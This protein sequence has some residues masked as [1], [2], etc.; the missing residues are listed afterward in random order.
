MKITLLNRKSL[1]KVNNKVEYDKFTVVLYFA[2]GSRRPKANASITLAAS[3]TT[4]IFAS[5]IR[6]KLKI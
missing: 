1:I 3:V 2:N 4:R 5:E 6:C